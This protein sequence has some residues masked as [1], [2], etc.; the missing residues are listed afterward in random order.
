[1]SEIHANGSNG[2]NG[3]GASALCSLDEFLAQQYDYIIIG[4]G[5]AG[6]VVAARLTEDQNVTVGVLEAGGNKLDDKSVLTPTLFP[7]LVG[8]K[9]YD[10][11]WESIPQVGLA[12]YQISLWIFLERCL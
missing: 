6:L 11:L 12:I 10:W 9:E 8:R 7:T 1:M 3:H 2:V 5:T 4:G